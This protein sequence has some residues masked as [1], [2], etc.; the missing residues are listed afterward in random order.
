MKA[1]PDAAPC[2]GVGLCFLQTLLV[3]KYFCLNPFTLMAHSVSRG[4]TSSWKNVFNSKSKAVN[5]S[6]SIW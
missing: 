6:L 4:S 2:V 5:L 1:G 3:P